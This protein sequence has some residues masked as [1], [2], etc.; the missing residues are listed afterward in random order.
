MFFFINFLHKLKAY[1]F[2]P[3]ASLG[4]LVFEQDLAFTVRDLMEAK[5]SLKVGKI[6]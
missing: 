3:P 4:H 6:L 5:L 2:L 1:K